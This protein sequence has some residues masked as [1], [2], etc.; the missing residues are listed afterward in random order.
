MNTGKSSIAR[1][2]NLLQI[3][4]SQQNWKSNAGTKPH[5]LTT[6]TI[7]EFT[8]LFDFSGFGFVF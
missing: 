7:T 5:I 4:D 3:A 6:S 2:Q 1:K 8:L